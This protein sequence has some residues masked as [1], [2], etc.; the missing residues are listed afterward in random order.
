MMRRSD[1]N[2][3]IL[4][5]VVLVLGG[6]GAGRDQ[7]SNELETR[8]EELQGEVDDPSLKLED[9]Q[10]RAMELAATLDRAAQAAPTADGRRAHW[11]EA[12]RRL[13]QFRARN[14]GMPHADR[15]QFQAAVYLWARARSWWQQWELSPTDR[16]AR[17]SAVADFDAALER[18]RPLGEATRGSDG[19]FAQNVRFRLAESLADRAEL[20]PEG[21]ESRPARQREAL[22]A[23]EPVPAEPALQGFA[24]LLRGELLTRLGKADQALPEVDAAAKAM[25]PPP[26]RDVLEARIAA[27]IGL[28]RFDDALKAVASSPV[29]GNVK[30]RLSVRVRLAR[31]AAEP[32]GAARAAAESALFAQVKELRESGSPETRLA[33]VALARGLSE[34]EPSQGPD[35]WDA[36]AEGAL[37]L[38]DLGRAAALE[39]KG[40]ARAETLGKADQAAALRLRAGALLFQAERFVEADALLSKVASEPKAGASRPKAGLLRALARGRALAARVPGVTTRA[41]AEALEAQV[42]DFPQD[43]STGEARWLLGKLR[44]AASDRHAA[45]TLWSDIPRDDPRWLDIRLAVAA[46]HQDDLDTQRINNDRERVAQRSHEARTFLETTLDQARNDSERAAVQLALARLDLTPEVG[47]PD[48]ARQL[49]ERVLH[50]ASQA[51]QR[52]QAR[53]L[54]ILALAELGRLIEAERGARDEANQ[55]RP[56]DLLDTARLLDQ[57]ASESE[58]DLRLR[59]FGLILR[60][61]LARVLD[62]LEGLPPEQ[63]WEAQLRQTRALIFSGDETRARTSL[64]AWGATTPPSPGDRLLMDLADTYAR[65]DAFDLA[66]DVQR[67]RMHGNPTGSL[68]WFAARY[69][70]ALAYYRSGRSREARQLIDATTILHPDLGGGELRDKFVHLRQRLG[71]D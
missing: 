55:A 27:L 32:P 43:P 12:V 34:P 28:G 9:R 31:R 66:A 71:P 60:V 47:H 17:A 33:L 57:V 37:A 61:L 53:R 44:L 45:L 30:G 49:C 58:S 26:A 14:P 69:G 70:L 56:A 62:R 64:S 22:E 42:R 1:P 16:A 36:M 8:L 21:D 48:Q 67:L 7:V 51:E 5:G 35:A 25:P 11:S 65:L 52:D 54:Q 63:R 50:S 4:V 29:E 3:A 10:Q 40:A 41:Y 24:R 38:G 19:L 13:D 68:P 59:Q 20:E 6:P 39:V 18:L 46:L 15:F 2:L 23:L